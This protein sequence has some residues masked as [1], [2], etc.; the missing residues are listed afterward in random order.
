MTSGMKGAVSLLS[1]HTPPSLLPVSHFKFFS[2]I[3]VIFP[4]ILTAPALILQT[5]IL[6]NTNLSMPPALPQHKI[7]HSPTQVVLSFSAS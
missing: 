3:H 6:H 1:A 5:I 7:L 2:I 4:L